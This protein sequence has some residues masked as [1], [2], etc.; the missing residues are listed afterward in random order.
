MTQY[1]SSIFI[2][3][4]DFR[5]IDNLGLIK[6]SQLS[7]SI[8]PIFIFTPTQIDDN[9]YKSNNCIQFMIES[10]DDLSLDIQ[11]NNGKLY[12]FYGHPDIIIKNLITKSN[13]NIDC[14]AVN[15]DYTPYSIQRDDKIKNICNLYNVDFLSFEDIL[16]NPVKSILT[17]ADNVYQKF[18]PYFRAASKI[19]INNPIKKKFNNFYN[20]SINLEYRNNIHDFYVPNDLIAVHGG[21]RNAL[22]IL[23]NIKNFKNY[24]SSRNFLNLNTTKLSAYIKFGCVS[25]REVY[26]TF[27]KKLGSNNDLI[28]QLYWRD[29]YYNI[30]FEFPYVFNKNSNLKEQYNNIK[31]LSN[32]KLFN[33]WKNGQ[34]G[35][36]VV[37]AAMTELNTTGFMHN[38]GR[39]IVS[40]F[41]IKLL[42]I[43]WEK[44]EHYFATQLVDY[45]PCVNNGNWQ[46]SAGS[47]ADSQPYFRTFNPWTQLE[48]FDKN[49]L[50][51]KKWLPQFSDIP[52]IDILNWD[53][54]FHKYDIDYP[55]PIIDY[56][57]QRSKI[58]D[59]YKQ[60][61]N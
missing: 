56:K 3:R 16:L 38:R 18:T 58:I 49:C 6:L 24:N 36:P 55:K 10:L 40:N 7:D 44:G 19:K 42:G 59:L 2:F 46:W 25:I 54:S 32:T 48:K 8:I 12:Y 41:L 14:V 5:L 31:W 51:I 34:T 15:M 43:N 27:L 1:K 39:L 52:P 50:Y 60:Y 35:F 47:G 29:F 37:D 9:S 23:K 45:D 21:R 30:A 61:L 22:K 57:L 53:N 33:K 20:H 28:K 26:H 17:G 13:L 4:R 11:K